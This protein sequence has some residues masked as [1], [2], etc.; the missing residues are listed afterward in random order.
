MTINGSNTALRDRLLQVGMIYP[1]TSGIQIDINAAFRKEGAGRVQTS[2]C[3]HN[4]TQEGGGGYDCPAARSKN[5]G[6]VPNSFAPVHEIISWITTAAAGIRNARDRF[7]ANG[8]EE[9]CKRFEIVGEACHVLRDALSSDVVEVNLFGGNPELHPD[10]ME[11]LRTLK[12]N[13]FRVNFTTTGR[14]FM[15]D[16]KFTAEFFESPSHV[17]ALSADD[18][19]LSELDRLLALDLNALQAEWRK[20]PAAYGQKQKACEA[21]YVGKLMAERGFSLL[22]F[23]MVLHPG[24]IGRAEAIIERLES[25]FPKAIVNPYPN[26]EGFHGGDATFNEEQLAVFGNLV[27]WFIERTMANDP[28]FVKRLQ[29][30]L[31]LKSAFLAWHGQSQKIARAI[32]GY[33][34]WRCYKGVGSGRYLQ[35]GSSPT[36]GSAQIA[37]GH[38]GCFWNRTTVTEEHRKVEH[39]DQVSKYLLGGMTTL[40]KES[41]SPCP[42]CAMPRLLFDLVNVES[43]MNDELIP[44]F[45]GL[46]KQHVGF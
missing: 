18:F 41:E 38:L 45:I 22:L 32:A 24:N 8:F 36:N 12:I 20:I 33:D 40:S 13:G 42:G 44:A 39:T 3:D 9:H 43:G 5:K 11:I 15:R 21:V 7:F 35:I 26:Q 27:D 6:M 37:G 16:T 19:E 31:L 17:L 23:N 1:V 28:R 29:Y 10:I 46:R 30:W 34:I 14:R 2:L 25:A 4:C